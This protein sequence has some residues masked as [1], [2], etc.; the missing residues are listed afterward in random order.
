MSLLSLYVKISS[1]LSPCSS[2]VKYSPT[3]WLKGNKLKT[4]LY[5]PQYFPKQSNSVTHLIA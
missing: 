1:I 5:S 4:F 2:M 3:V